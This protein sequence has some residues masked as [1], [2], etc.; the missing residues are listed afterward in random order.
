[1]HGSMRLPFSASGRHV[2]R[3]FKERRFI[4]AALGAKDFVLT[5]LAHR[6]LFTAILDNPAISKAWGDSDE[7]L[8]TFLEKRPLLVAALNVPEFT[9]KALA[10]RGFLTEVLAE[11]D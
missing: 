7:A 6:R 10:D 8:L 11:R 9:E 1:M 5:A 3:L 2:V 4:A